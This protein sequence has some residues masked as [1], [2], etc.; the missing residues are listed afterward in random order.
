MEQIDTS[1]LVRWFVGLNRRSRRN[2]ATFLKSATAARQVACTLHGAVLRHRTVQRVRSDDH[3]FIGGASLPASAPTLF[4][5]GG[6]ISVAS[7]AHWPEPQNP[8]GSQSARG[9]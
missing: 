2:H 3:V 7:A 5:R 9:P 4:R 8:P 6:L 1:V